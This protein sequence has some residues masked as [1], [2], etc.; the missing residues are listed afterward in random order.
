[1]LKTTAIKAIA[2]VSTTA[3]YLLAS[4]TL[5]ELLKC[6]ESSGLLVGMAIAKTVVPV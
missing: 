4:R 3:P 2:N 5:S 6:V 1:M